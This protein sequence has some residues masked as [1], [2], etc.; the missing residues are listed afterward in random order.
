MIQGQ[1]A[2]L[3]PHHLKDLDR[4]GLQVDLNLRRLG[5][6]DAVACELMVPFSAL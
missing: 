6:V 2:V 1:A 5:A 4:T 3:N